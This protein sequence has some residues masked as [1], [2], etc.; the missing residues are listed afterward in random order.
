MEINELYKL[1]KQV[2]ELSAKNGFV[3]LIGQLRTSLSQYKQLK[4]VAAQT[5]QHVQQVNNVKTAIETNRNQALK[6][7]KEI[8]NSL[9]DYKLIK[10]S[11][12]LK[13]NNLYGDEVISMLNRIGTDFDLR[14]DPL[15]A[16]I[17]QYQQK[18]NS[19]QQF[20][21]SLNI[22]LED[23]EESSG[24]DEL[25]IFFE[26]GASVNNLK[27]LSKVSADWN[28]IVNCFGRLTKE[29]NTDINIVSIERGSLIATVS[30]ASLIIMGIIKCS[31][32]ILDLIL[33]I[34]EIKKK[35]LELK[36]MKLDSIAA[37]IEILE[38]QSTLNLPDGAKIITK[39]LMD[40]FGWE[41]SSDLY[42]ETEGATSNA[43]KKLIQFHNSGGK[44]DSKILNPN[45]EQ[46]NS[47][48]SLKEK[49][50]KFLKVEEEV[51][52]LTNGK[53]ILRIEGAGDNDKED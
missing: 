39:E 23:L 18:L 1:T 46:S 27:E 32:K 33:K 2:S 3:N 22:V 40:E 7:L 43:V 34:Y 13:F 31:D 4:S 38:K 25:I 28:Q 45:E 21:N 26:G 37:A 35:A 49:N 16:E 17:T 10:T 12:K 8:Q 36:S 9:Q 29:N 42:N 15:I 52:S 47:S 50:I 20:V 41:P 24:K 19:Y 30:I 51:N 14:P 5:P 53:E 6:L 44:V 11:K 48:L